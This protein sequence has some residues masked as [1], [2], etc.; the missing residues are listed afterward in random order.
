MQKYSRCFNGK[1]VRFITDSD[2]TWVN[3]EDISAMIDVSRH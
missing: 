1:S 2:G 3:I